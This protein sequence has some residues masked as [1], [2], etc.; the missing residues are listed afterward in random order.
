RRGL[1][2]NQCCA[3]DTLK[4]VF[5]QPASAANPK[6]VQQSRQIGCELRLQSGTRFIS[7]SS[8]LR[9]RSSH[10]NVRQ[11][12]ANFGIGTL[13]ATKQ[14][15]TSRAAPGLLRCARNDD[16]LLTIIYFGQ[17]ASSESK[18]AIKSLPSFDSG[19][20]SSMLAISFT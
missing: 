16:Y 1:G 17:A 15:R 20:T 14:S 18:M 13:A 4:N 12:R 6:F 10:Q 7:F 11:S 5:Q 19:S 9:F 3:S 2:L 8:V